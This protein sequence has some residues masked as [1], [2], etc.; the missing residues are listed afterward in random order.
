MRRRK[1]FSLDDDVAAYIEEHKNES[2]FVNDILKLHMFNQRCVIPLPLYERLQGVYIDVYP[3]IC[4]IIQAEEKTLSQ[5]QY[6]VS[7]GI[8]KVFYEICKGLNVDCSVE[9]CRT[10]ITGKLVK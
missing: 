2:K 9:E 10:F 3:E 7:E 4:T 5:R 8:V 1:T 6:R